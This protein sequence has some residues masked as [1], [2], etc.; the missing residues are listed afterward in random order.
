MTAGDPPQVS[1]IS[2]L[3]LQSASCPGVTVSQCLR[4][5]SGCWWLSLAPDSR[6][7][8]HDCRGPVGLRAIV[9]PRQWPGGATISHLLSFPESCLWRHVRGWQ[10]AGGHLPGHSP[11]Q[12]S[13][14]IRD[15]SYQ[16]SD[17]GQFVR[18]DHGLRV[19]DAVLLR[20]TLYAVCKEVSGTRPPSD[21][22]Y[23]DCKS[24]RCHQWATIRRLVFP[25][26]IN[27]WYNV[28][29]VTSSRHV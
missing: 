29:I 6:V 2:P 14:S 3:C 18:C 22:H 7:P 25:T 4:P 13:G 26:E 11:H 27:M 12:P 24:S 8:A 16:C 15:T 17:R 5:G 21:P 28:S 20:E 1:L 9:A 10:S 23:I 19:T